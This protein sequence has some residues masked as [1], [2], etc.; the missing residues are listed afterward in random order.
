MSHDGLVLV[1]DSKVDQA[2]VQPGADLGVYDKVMLAKPHIAFKK[3]WQRDQNRTRFGEWRVTDEDMERIVSRT[4]DLFGAVFFEVLE[5]HNYP[6]VSTAG[7]DVLLVRPAIIDLDVTAPNVSAVPLS[8]TYAAR[9]ADAT[10][11]MELYDSVT[12]QILIRAIDKKKG[13][14]KD[15]AWS[16]MRNE[17]GNR[18]DAEKAFRFWA[19][20]LVEALDNARKGNSKEQ[21][22][23]G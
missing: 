7:A 6:V 13:K 11:F 15:L 22:G 12:G 1:E 9:G 14:R 23:N 18:A 10:L 21:A 2:Y 16:I 19:E 17:T 20:L 4:K 8:E 5:E 3:K